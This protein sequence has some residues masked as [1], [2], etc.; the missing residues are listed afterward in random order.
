MT[1]Q[2]EYDVSDKDAAVL[3]RAFN[4]LPP[5]LQTT[6]ATLIFELTAK[7][8]TIRRLI[9]MVKEKERGDEDH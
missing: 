4:E 7:D 5:N 1:T 3:L 9:E 2:I 8:R 6:I